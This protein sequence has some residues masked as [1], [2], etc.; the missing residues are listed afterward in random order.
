[1]E[2][3]QNKLETIPKIQI[4]DVNELLSNMDVDSGGENSCTTNMVETSL[5]ST[6]ELLEMQEVD[7]QL[8]ESGSVSMVDKVE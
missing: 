6:E 2:P 1:M 8:V 7:K 3:A 5:P 4:G